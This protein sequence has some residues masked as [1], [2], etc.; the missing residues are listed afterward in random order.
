MSRAYDAVFLAAELK[1]GDARENVTARAFWAKA[2]RGTP[3]PPH[4]KEGTPYGVTEE[5]VRT[6]L[7]PPVLMRVAALLCGVA[8]FIWLEGT[9]VLHRVAVAPTPSYEERV[10]HV[11]A[12]SRRWRCATLHARRCLVGC[13]CVQYHRV[14]S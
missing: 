13:V 8:L 4:A 7:M 11:A 1:P 12:C 2:E 3:A 6:W 5:R 9:I 10:S 14:H